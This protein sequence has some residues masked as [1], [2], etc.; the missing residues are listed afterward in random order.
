VPWVA[1]QNKF[2]CPCHASE[3]DIRGEVSSP[4]APRAL[5]IFPLEIRNNILSVDTSKP[6][7]RARFAASQVT[8]AKK[9]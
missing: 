3:F 4:P 1:A 6:R 2:V 7:K 9:T 5:D 8:Y